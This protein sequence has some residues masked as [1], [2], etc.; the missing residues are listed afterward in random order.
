MTNVVAAG[1]PVVRDVTR[2]QPTAVR[3]VALVTLALSL[4]L[5]FLG[6]EA[7]VVLGRLQNWF[8]HGRASTPYCSFRARTGLPCVGCGGTRALALVARGRLIAAWRVNALGAFAG[9]AAWL[10]ALAGL[11]A[12]VSGRSGA[13][14]WWLYLVPP[15]GVLVFFVS[16]LIWWRALPA[17]SF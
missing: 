4:A 16:W 9:L 12:A 14:R 5:V 7:L 8:D 13:L 10:L 6:S 17:G 15:T 11:A 2:L 3:R 1:P